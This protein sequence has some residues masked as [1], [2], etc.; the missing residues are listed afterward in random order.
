MKL[1]KRT[2]ALPIDTIS[3]FEQ[4]VDS[5][6]RS[7]VLAGLIDQYIEGCQRAA[8]RKDLEEGCREMWDVYLETALEWE[9]ADDTLHETVA[10]HA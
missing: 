7:A 10:Y 1:Q 6:K 9:Q 3:K 2:Y 5:G 8:L 4:S